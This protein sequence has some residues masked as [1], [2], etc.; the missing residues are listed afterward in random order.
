MEATSGPPVTGAEQ[1]LQAAHR[2]IRDLTSRIEN[3]RDLPE[4]LGH[5]REYRS[6]LMPHFLDEEGV[7]GLYEMI[8]RM[9]P[10]QLGLADALLKEHGALLA[11]IDRV[12]ERARA[13]LAGPVAAVLDE[14]RA[15][16]RR[17]GAHEAREDALLLDTMYTDLG[18]GE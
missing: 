11:E 14:A 1:S 9:S 2:R 3:V 6:V 8:R 13:C 15:L 17:V 5:L 12:A 7:D 4:L 10:R 16:A 18:H